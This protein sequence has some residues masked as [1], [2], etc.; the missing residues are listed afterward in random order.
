M[1]KRGVCSICMAI[2]GLIAVANWGKAQDSQ[3]V[4]ILLQD[5]S[6]I[7][8]GSPSQSIDGD[9]LVRTTDLNAKDSA[10]SR[11][12]QPSQSGQAAASTVSR[13]MTEK[14]KAEYALRESFL[15][16]THYL[17]IGLG[18]TIDELR[19]RRQ[20][21]KTTGDRVADGLTRYAIGFGTGASKSLLGSGL[22]PIVFKQDPRYFASNK[23]GFFA[24]AS[25]AAS[26]VFVT[27]GDSG[28]LEPNYSLLGGDLSASA[29]ANI[30]ER[31]TPGHRRIGLSPT[32]SRLGI[33]VGTDMA[34][35][36]IFQEFWPDIKRKLFGK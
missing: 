35:F 16:P 13:P 26:R 32:V 24:R 22:Y 19:E 21:Q 6:R 31:D 17:T 7:C 5:E 9:A 4:R 14:A 25:Y 28:S 18:A 34:S 23:K 20:P 30:W 11:P 12:A 8:S 10:P 36:V 3:R 15:S 2:L 1:S 27:R 33:S 29:L